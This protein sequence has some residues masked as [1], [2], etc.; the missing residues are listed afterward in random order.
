LLAYDITTPLVF[1]SLNLLHLLA[2]RG[3][4][5]SRY[6]KTVALLSLVGAG[7]FLLNVLF[8]KEG[9][10]AW[11]R[12][13]AVFLRS[14]T[15]ISISV[16]YIFLVDPYDLIRSCMQILKLPPKLGYAL[17]AGWNVIPLIQR[18]LTIIRQAHQV[19]LGG[20]GKPFKSFHQA[21][22]VLLSGAVRHGERVTLSMAARGI[23][24]VRNRTFIKQIIWTKQDT[25]YCIVGIVVS[26]GAF[27]FV[28]QTGQ[29]IFELG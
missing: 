7:L 22:V 20:K 18:D 5:Y 26:G 21:A 4:E 3:I 12:G 19:R 13:T 24:E 14:T 25:L 27:L 6:L 16:G 17:F 11:Y 8:P 15:L 23:E 29:F 9:V 10:D 28:L 2:F 1:F